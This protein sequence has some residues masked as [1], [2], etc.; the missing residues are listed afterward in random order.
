MH[1]KSGTVDYEFMN[2]GAAGAVVELVV[3]RIKKSHK[4]S[5][6]PNSFAN[7]G[8]TTE[9]WLDALGQGYI[10]TSTDKFGTDDLQGRSPVPDDI[11]TNPDYS[12]LKQYSKCKASDI[13]FAEV[14]RQSFS[15]TSGSRKNVRIKLPGDVYNPCDIPRIAGYPVTP[16]TEAIANY[17]PNAVDGYPWDYDNASIP[18][19]DSHTYFIAISTAGEKLSRIVTKVNPA[20]VLN[21]PDTSVVLDE[22]APSKV[23]YYCSYTEEIGSCL[24]SDKAHQKLFV[25]GA[26]QYP[27]LT[28][29]ES[30]F[31]VDAG[32]VL[33][34][35]TGVQQ[36]Q[37]IVKKFNAAGAPDGVERN[38]TGDVLIADR[39][40]F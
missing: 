29:P 24:Y 7:G 23:Q 35:A 14:N 6:D 39:H 32:L 19:V 28:D 34:L 9:N 12:F 33:E 5:Y 26:R 20:L 1:F 4:L 2:K 40:E 21:D 15:L 22:Y 18:V 16:A 25:R 31:S 17:T 8:A 38:E 36:A 27:V 37:S 3:Y 30:E 10:Q 13:P 11:L